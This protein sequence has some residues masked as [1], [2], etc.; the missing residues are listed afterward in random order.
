MDIAIL[1]YPMPQ[2]IPLN[3]PTLP[4]ESAYGFL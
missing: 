2:T 4:R 3:P 1:G